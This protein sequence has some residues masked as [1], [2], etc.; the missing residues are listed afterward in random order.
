MPDPHIHYLALEEKNVAN[1]SMQYPIDSCMF[2]LNLL[3]DVN[4]LADV[5]LILC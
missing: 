1:S 2:K 4:L 3:S 5:Y